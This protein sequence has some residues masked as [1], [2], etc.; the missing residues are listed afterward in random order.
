[1]VNAPTDDPEKYYRRNIF[2]PF[3]DHLINQLKERFRDK[4]DV[5]KQARLQELMLVASRL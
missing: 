4:N 3:L 5:P 1:M 2:I